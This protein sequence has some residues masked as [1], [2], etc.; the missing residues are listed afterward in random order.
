LGDN[1]KSGET[2]LN[3]LNAR[4]LV[5]ADRQLGH[6]GSYIAYCSSKDFFR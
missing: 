6:I 3:I 4:V 5:G 1:T 2:G